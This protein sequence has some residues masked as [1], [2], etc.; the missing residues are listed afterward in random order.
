MPAV[1]IYLSDEESAIVER[2]AA[3]RRDS[4]EKACHDIIRN[5]LI[6]MYGLEGEIWNTDLPEQISV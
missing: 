6:I 2:I 4:K 1:T 3:A 5:E